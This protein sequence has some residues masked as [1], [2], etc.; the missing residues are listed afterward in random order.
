[1]KEKNRQD[2]RLISVVNQKGGVGKSTTAINVSAYLVKKGYSTLIVDLDPQSNA[3]SGLGVYPENVKKSTYD[4]IIDH[5]SPEEV[6]YNTDYEGLDLLPSSERL[7]GAEVELVSA[8]KREYRLKTILDKLKQYYDYILVDCSP[9]LG[10]LTINALTATTEVLIPLQCEY[11]ALEGIARLLKTTELVR[12]SLNKELEISGVVLTMHSRTKLSGQ[13]V[14]EIKKY[15]PGKVF[16][17]IIPRNIRL[18]EAPS[19]GKPVMK[20][21]PGCAGAK[22]YESLTDEIINRHRQKQEKIDKEIGSLAQK[23]KEFWDT[24]AP[25]KHAAGNGKTRVDA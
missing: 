24:G 20:Y 4:A 23:M 8:L 7:A 13:A 1:M 19:Y 5:A 15:F 10:L 12:Q 18:A 2:C 22:A 21:A 17:T 16:N 25:P 6:V 11:Y 3:T 14:K 9:A